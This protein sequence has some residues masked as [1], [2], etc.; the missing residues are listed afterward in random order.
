MLIFSY[1]NSAEVGIVDTN[2]LLIKK[3][4]SE[5]SSKFGFY[6]MN[7]VI[8]I[9]DT[10]E[11]IDGYDTWYKTKRGYVK[12]KHVI[13]EK[14]LPK[15]ISPNEVIYSKFALQLIVYQDTVVESLQ[16]LRKILV[17]EK[18]IYL[19]KTKNVFVIYLANFSS[20]T[21][22][23]LKRKEI[24]SYFPSAFITKIKDKRTDLE[25]E[26]SL[27]MSN[28]ELNE[29]VDTVADI[30]GKNEYE[31]ENLNT[32]DEF[33]SKEELNSLKND[34]EEVEVNKSKKETKTIIEEVEVEEV[35]IK[36]VKKE[37]KIKEKPIKTVEAIQ[38]DVIQEV[39]DVKE[40]KIVQTNNKAPQTYQS[41]L[42][43]LLIFINKK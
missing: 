8:Q 40:D 2:I 10:V 5:N 6:K 30:G 19:E 23:N 3:Y 27:S 21:A 41:I 39:D 20:Y 22:A 42:E 26:I 36:A 28:E 1:A 31:E 29:K 17:N 11:S 24:K 7:K 15:F 38:K 25:R 35:E 14:N 43:N 32:N 9:L 33:I 12:S 16:K 34:V 13:L 37:E 18:Y 4:P